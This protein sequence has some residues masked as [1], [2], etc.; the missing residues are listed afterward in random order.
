MD[1]SRHWLKWN[2]ENFPVASKLLPQEFRAPILTFYAFARGAD[3]I[4]DE[5]S[6]A[7]GRQRRLRK[8]ED[9]LISGKTDGVPAFAVPFI[10]LTRTQPYLGSRARDLISAFVQDTVKTRY[11]DFQDLLDYCQRSAAPVGR[12]VLFICEEHK[13]D[14]EAS[15]ALCS[16]LQILNHIQDCGDDY[17]NMDRV[18]IPLNWFKEAGAD[19]KMLASSEASEKMRYILNRALDH[20][21]K[22]LLRARPLPATL[23]NRRVKREVTFIYLLAQ[24]LS[25]RLRTRDPLASHVKL[26]PFTVAASLLDVVFTI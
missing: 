19:V 12:I 17:V 6:P 15:D 5:R 20:C 25:R 7:D 23:T 8:L 16:A 11:H 2:P 24:K 10:A 9:A 26:G 21:D 13:A 22:L 1:Y 4:A 14:M 18:Y 3:E